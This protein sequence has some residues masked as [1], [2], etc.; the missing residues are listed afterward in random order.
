ML[1]LLLF[2]FPPTLPTLGSQS[3]CTVAAFRA[4]F[5]IIA[6]AYVSV[7]SLAACF[8]AMLYQ[9]LDAISR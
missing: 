6:V 7:H 2:V 3:T 9:L 5:D 1:F 4:V 8:T